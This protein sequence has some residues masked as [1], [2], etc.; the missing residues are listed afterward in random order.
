MAVGQ[1]IPKYDG[2]AHATGAT[3]YIADIQLPGMVHVKVRGSDHHNARILSVDTSKAEALSGVV[4]V[5]TYRDVPQNR[6]GY[7]NDQLVLAE[8]YTR[9]V[10]QPIVAVAAEDVTIAEEAVKLIDIEYEV[11]EPVFDPLE[12]M[13]PDAPVIHEGGNVWNFGTYDRLRIRLGDVE[14][15]FSEADYVFED[16]FISQWQE[17][18]PIETHAAFAEV[19][20]R[21]KVTVHTVGHRVFSFQE[22]LA[23]VLQMPLTKVRVVGGTVG[24][25]FGGKGELACEAV[26]ALVALETGRPAKWV[27]T[28]E[29]EFTLSTSRSS[30][31]LKMKTGVK[32]DGTIVA[33]QVKSIKDSGAYFMDGGTGIKKNAIFG[34][35]PYNI[36][37]YHY[38]GYLAFT[39]KTPAG[40]LR[41]YGVA[42]DTMAFEQQM[43]RIARELGMD[44]IEI[45]LKNTLRDGDISATGHPHDVVSAEE[46]LK[47]VAEA[48]RWEARKPLESDGVIKR[49]RGVCVSH[50]N[51]GATRGGESS[52]AQVRINADGTVNLL[53]GTVDVGQGAKTVLAQMT[54]EVLGIPLETITVTNADTETTPIDAGTGASQVTYV[55]G[56]AVKNAAED[57]R[58]QLLEVATE[59]MEIAPED[60]DIKDGLI[61]VEGFPERNLTFA[62]VAYKAVK[63]QGRFLMGKG[64]YV[65]TTTTPFN[66]ETGMCVPYEAYGYGASI[67]EVAVDTETGEVTVEK[68]YTACDV[69][70][71]I[72]PLLVEGQIEGGASIDL[73]FALTE[74]IY[75][76]YPAFDF[77]TTGF[78]DYLLLTAMDMP[79][80]MQPVIVEKPSTRGPWGAKGIG[81]LTTTVVAGAVLNA[82]YDATGV[83]IKRVPASPETVLRA[84][85]E[86]E[87]SIIE[88]VIRDRE[89]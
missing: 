5:L 82:I 22:H 30:Y 56:N 83:Q 16:V 36:P 35:G 86:G 9:Y 10:H 54:A 87:N 31:I 13:G 49:G 88:A 40:A 29:E 43:D 64:N 71:A 68:L 85:K 65:I 69:G 15:G 77:K 52:M 61:F 4:C 78:H 45:R 28:R 66:Y 6:F 37:D 23:E 60:L 84:L 57:A 42:V 8:E 38:D 74:N 33:R 7:S 19:D 62:E 73:G 32:K 72:N 34:R 58:R 81:E 44:S 14:Q 24:G 55:T 39:N 3:K 46:V 17:Q 47:A 20:P 25:S 79:R 75:P 41:S 80:Q 2:I 1:R 50:M 70:K 63:E 76:G 11:L 89:V 12:A 51:T 48:Y 27:W 21:G 26:A 18:A 67:A 53:I 59:E